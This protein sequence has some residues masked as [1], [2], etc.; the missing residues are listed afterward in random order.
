VL[1]NVLGSVKSPGTY[2]G[3]PLDPAGEF[4]RKAGGLT[5]GASSRNIEIL[6]DGETVARADLTR[7]EN[8][9]DVDANPPV[10]DGDAVFVPA[11]VEFM[12]VRGAVAKPGTYELVDGETVASAIELAGGFARGAIEDSVGVRGFRDGTQTSAVVDMRSAAGASRGLEDGDQVYVRELTEWRRVTHVTVEGE[13]LRPGPYGI[14]EGVD[15]MSDAIERAGGLTPDAWVRGVRLVR[16]RPLDAPDPEFERLVGMP[17]G[18]MTRTEYDYFRNRQLDRMSVVSSYEDVLDGDESAD[19][20]LMDGDTVVVPKRVDT[21]E[22]LGRVVRPG[23]V[24]HVPGKHYGYYVRQAGGYASSA[25]SGRTRVISGAT[26]QWTS[27]RRA[28]RMEPGDL[29][30]VPERDDTDWWKL[31]REAVA[32]VASIVTTYVVLD[33][34]TN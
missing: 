21:V 13:V 23:R 19:A 4:I 29:V 1:V 16:P 30:W 17:V 12:D 18:D 26:G 31:V 7:Y 3:S 14:D 28:G 15:R 8:T 5:V 27:A 9:G 22:V 6:R 24:A 32:L 20:I 11:A 2:Q 10:L 34:A 25:A 33:Q